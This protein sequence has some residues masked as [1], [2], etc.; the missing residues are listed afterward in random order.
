MQDI[1]HGSFLDSNA[2]ESARFL[3]GGATEVQLD[4]QGRFVVPTALL[5]H[6]QLQEEVVFVGLGQ[7]LEVWSSEKWQIQLDYLSSHGADI[8]QRLADDKDSGLRT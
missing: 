5:K 1:E 7:W 3:L 8:A 4:S 2:R 6:A